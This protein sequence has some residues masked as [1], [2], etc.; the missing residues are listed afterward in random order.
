MSAARP[1][2][3]AL[4]HPIIDTSTLTLP[5]WLIKND[6]GPT[7]MKGRTLAEVATMLSVIKRPKNKKFKPQF[8][9]K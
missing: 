1:K 5:D 9:D 6:I 8:N 3:L 2:T 7:Y 4:T